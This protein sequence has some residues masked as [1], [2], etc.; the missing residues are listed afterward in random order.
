LTTATTTPVIGLGNPARQHRTLR[1]QSLPEHHQTELIDT[2][3]R[4]QIRAHKGN[5]THVEVFQMGSVRT[6][7][8][9]RPRRLSRHQHADRY[10]YTLNWDE[11]T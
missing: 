11:P 8:I 2:A 6:S 9:G 3:E 5:V 10:R 4:R 1:L 7:I